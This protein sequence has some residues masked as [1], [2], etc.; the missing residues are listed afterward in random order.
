MNMSGLIQITLPL[1]EKVG[2]HFDYG[3][4]NKLKQHVGSTMFLIFI[5]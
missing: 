1:T 2:Q 5:F 3:I 4:Q